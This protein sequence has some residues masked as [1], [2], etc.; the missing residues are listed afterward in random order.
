MS[1]KVLQFCEPF[2]TIKAVQD[3]KEYKIGNKSI[4]VNLSESSIMVKNRPVNHL[5]S[6]I[7]TNVVVNNLKRAIIVED[8]ERNIDHAKL[9]EEIKKKWPLVYDMTKQERHKGILLWR[10]SK[11]KIFG[12]TEINLCYIAAN[13]STG[14]HKMHPPDFTE[15]HTQILGVGKMQKT[16]END[17]GTLYQ[18]VILAPGMTHDPFYDEQVVYPWHQYQSV[19]EAIFMAVEIC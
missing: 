8:Y 16:E 14:L 9:F 6:T 11:E 4:V 18:E 13:V 12:N 1:I 7:V 3:E 5:K 19:T 15:V 17:Y 2:Y 10:S